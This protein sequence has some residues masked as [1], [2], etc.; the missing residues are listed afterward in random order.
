MKRVLIQREGGKWKYAGHLDGI[1]MH[2]ILK[3]EYV[4]TLQ[5]REGIIS[6][7][8]LT[9]PRITAYLRASLPKR[10]KKILQDKT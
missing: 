5:I 2:V 6:L 10:K 9:A 3:Q 8:Q 1:W 7:R 4:I